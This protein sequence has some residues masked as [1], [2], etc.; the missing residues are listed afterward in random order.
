MKASDTKQKA[1]EG[2]AVRL[3]RWIAMMM[4]CALTAACGPGRAVTPFPDDPARIEQA[5]ALCD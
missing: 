1:E 5:A 3:G 2:M 4:V